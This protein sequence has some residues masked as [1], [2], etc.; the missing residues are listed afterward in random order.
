MRS[1]PPELVIAPTVACVPVEDVRA[2]L[3]VDGTEED[4]VIEGAIAAAVS[5][6]DG[7]GGILGRALMEQTWRQYL[8]CWPSSRSIRLAL[9]PAISIEA[10]EGR[11]ADGDTVALDPDDYRLIGKAGISPQ[12]IIN[13]DVALPALAGGPDA[14]SITF[15]AGYGAEPE[16]LPPALRAA[17]MLMAGD[18]FRF[19]STVQLGASAAVAMSTTVD[20]LVGPFRRLQI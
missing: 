4:A 16:F 2:H 17:I 12:L 8:P 3:R 10:I 13:P 6:L 11:G 19:R 14:I 9:A 7:Y 15:K 5:H 18:L 1:L 20:R